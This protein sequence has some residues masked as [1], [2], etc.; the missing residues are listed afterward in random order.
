MKKIILILFAFAYFVTLRAQ[1]YTSTDSTHADSVTIPHAVFYATSSQNPMPIKVTNCIYMM[2][3]KVMIMKSGHSRA[4]KIST[5][6]S[7]GSVVTPDGNIISKN[8]KVIMLT[9]GQCIDMDG[10]IAELRTSNM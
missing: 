7:D 1:N 2:E 8:G 9:N 10:N 4:L 5:T 6:L 3:N